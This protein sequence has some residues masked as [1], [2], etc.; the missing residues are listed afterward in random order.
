MLTLRT[1]HRA[2]L[3]DVKARPTL[4]NADYLLLSLDTALFQ[5]SVYCLKSKKV[6]ASSSSSGVERRTLDWL[7][8]AVKEYGK[9][10]AFPSLILPL[11]R[12]GRDYSQTILEVHLEREIMGDVVF[13][14]IEKEMSE[15]SPDPLE[16]FLQM[17]YPTIFSLP[18]NTTDQKSEGPAR[19]ALADWLLS[20]NRTHLVSFAGKS[21]EYEGGPFNG[22][23]VRRQISATLAGYAN[24]ETVS[25]LI[26]AKENKHT[27]IPSAH[28]AMLQSTFCLQPPG[29]SATRKGF[30]ESIL[31]GCIPVVFRRETYARVWDGIDWDEIA[32]V[33]EEEDFLES[34]ADIV[35][36]LE[37]VSQ[38]DVKR[39][40]RDIATLAAR[41]QYGMPTSGEGVEWGGDAFGMLL[42]RLDAIKRRGSLR[43]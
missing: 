26:P 43:G 28:L 16:T 35:R 8:L 40:Q 22:F 17:P 3:V 33:V 9:R 30:W 27:F 39:R 21:P 1:N 7:R 19:E 34:Q 4:E 38:R 32:V 42:R 18:L 29:D 20:R 10:R 36:T 13:V 37:G 2:G 12:I 15:D 14:G 24:N 23:A 25:V 5:Q 11:S 41:V 6:P 31:M